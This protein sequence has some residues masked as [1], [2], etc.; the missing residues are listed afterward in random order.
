MVGAPQRFRRGLPKKNV[1]FTSN[2]PKNEITRTRYNRPEKWKIIFTMALSQFNDQFP[3]WLF[4]VCLFVEDSRIVFF[5]LYFTLVWN[6]TH[7]CCL[8]EPKPT[9]ANRTEMPVNVMKKGNQTKL[10]ELLNWTVKI[11]R[12][13]DYCGTIC[14]GNKS[15]N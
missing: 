6:S 14:L 1:Q 9:T 10:N 7:S 2:Q 13:R 12:I 5:L 15:S 11:A 4:N 3:I 8:L